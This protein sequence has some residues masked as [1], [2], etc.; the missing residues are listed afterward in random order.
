M[1]T[2]TAVKPRILIML[3]RYL[4]GVKSGGPIR[5]ISNLVDALGH[6]MDFR[7][8]TTD[9]D[10]GDDT[11]YKSIEPN[12]WNEVGKAQVLYLSP[13]RLGMRSMF[14]VLASEKADFLYLNSFFSTRFS[15][16]PLLLRELGARGQKAVLLAPRGEFSPG[17]L[18]WHRRRKKTWIGM[19]RRVRPYR[20]LVWHASSSHEEQDIRRVFGP[21]AAVRVALPLSSSGPPPVTNGDASLPKN[22]GA[23]KVVFV[24]RIVPKKNLLQAIQMLKNISGEVEFNIYGPAEDRAYWRLCEDGISALPGNVH[25]EFRS[26]VE[27][28]AVGRIF[29]AHHLFLFPTL[30]ENYG[31][32]I[33]EALTAGCPVLISN[34]TPWKDLEQSNAGWDLPLDRPELFHA[35]LQRCVAMTDTEFRA[36]SACARAFVHRFTS[37]ADLLEAN[38]ALFTAGKTGEPSGLRIIPG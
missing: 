28:S 31:H 37:D 35:A 32:V 29:S 18:Q 33:F 23:L 16:V 14:A 24:S 30:G 34:H 11:H 8:I 22:P 10:D 6:E 5:S 1:G 9:R 19:A 15:I 26:V 25:V 36:K 7:I 4:P 27:H 38:R 2:G 20:T 17:A 13:D 3:Y 12:R 21:G